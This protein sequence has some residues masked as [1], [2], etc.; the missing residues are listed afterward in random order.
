[1]NEI[2]IQVKTNENGKVSESLLRWD[3]EAHLNWDELVEHKSSQEQLLDLG[4]QRY[5]KAVR[6]LQSKAQ[7]EILMA[8]RRREQYR[9]VKEREYKMKALAEACVALGIPVPEVP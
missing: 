2:I 3:V 6:I 7:E 1:M 5:Y 8:D 9:L 4:E